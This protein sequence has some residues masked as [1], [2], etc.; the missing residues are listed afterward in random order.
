MSFDNISTE[1]N[2]I[3][4]TFYPKFINNIRSYH[5][6]TLKEY[7]NLMTIV[8]EKIFFIEKFLRI[9]KLS[10]EH[11]C[12]DNIDI[13]IIDDDK[14]NIISDYLDIFN[15]DFDIYDMILNNYISDSE[16]INSISDDDLIDTINIIKLFNHEL[17][18]KKD[19]INNIIKKNPH[20]LDDEDV[21]EYIQNIDK[22]KSF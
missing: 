1:S 3:M 11:A 14:K 8:N 4:I 9:S 18:N 13:T 21:T 22:P 5:K 16:S 19:D 12:N 7:N 2:I 20:L 10:Y 6:L 17:N 15:N